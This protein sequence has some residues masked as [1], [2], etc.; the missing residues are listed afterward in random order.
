M[1]RQTFEQIAEVVAA[2]VQY[3]EV[4]GRSLGWAVMEFHVALDA[5]AAV[6]TFHGVELVSR[7]MVVTL[8]LC[9]PAER[10]ESRR[11][12]SESGGGCGGDNSGSCM[13]WISCVVA[14]R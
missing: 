12:S 5:A 8:G 9:E 4:T 10:S 7:N 1:V 2:D 13:R 3:D 6:E 14:S 11:T